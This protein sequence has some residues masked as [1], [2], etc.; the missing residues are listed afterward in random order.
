MPFKDKADKKRYMDIYNPIYYRVNK[1]RL[2]QKRRV[3]YLEA[4]G[5]KIMASLKTTLD[6]PKDR[7]TISIILRCIAAHLITAE[8][9][10]EGGYTPMLF[11]DCIKCSD[12]TLCRP[13][14]QKIE[15][16]LNG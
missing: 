1:K 5:D 11:Q 7:I 13:L 14:R 6:Y 12:I 10:G 2:L 3:R 9:Q 4:K 16:V 8:Y 15:E